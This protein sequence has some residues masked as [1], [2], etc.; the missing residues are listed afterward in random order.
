MIRQALTPA[1]ALALGFG[2]P[3]LYDGPHEFRYFCV[4][5]IAFGLANFAIERRSRRRRA[6]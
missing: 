6:P 1:V 5:V 4:L 3:A 2:F